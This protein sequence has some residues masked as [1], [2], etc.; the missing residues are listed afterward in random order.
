VDSRPKATATESRTFVLDLLFACKKIAVP[1][2][3]Q[4]KLMKKREVS[5]AFSDYSAVAEPWAP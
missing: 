4:E 3:F 2:S 1:E 5:L